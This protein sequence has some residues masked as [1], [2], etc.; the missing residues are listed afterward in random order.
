MHDPFDDTT[1]STSATDTPV[2]GFSRLQIELD[3]LEQAVD[4]LL[5]RSRPLLTPERDATAEL[6]DR[7]P[8]SGISSC[9]YRVTHMR[10]RIEDIAARLDA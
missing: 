3:K 10:R 6:V 2:S 4:L 5:D 1:R 9:A 8:D 7:A